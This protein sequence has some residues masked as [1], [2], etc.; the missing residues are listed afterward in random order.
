MT[1]AQGGEK[2]DLRVPFLRPAGDGSV[3]HAVANTVRAARHSLAA[4]RKRLRSATA[5]RTHP[6][7]PLSGFAPLFSFGFAK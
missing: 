6:R 2:R 4:L 7:P 3:G 5:L 1:A